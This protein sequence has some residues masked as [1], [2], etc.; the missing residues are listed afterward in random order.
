MIKLKVDEYITSFIVSSVYEFT[1]IHKLHQMCFYD[2]IKYNTLQLFNIY[3][4][5]TP[6]WGSKSIFSITNE[7]GRNTDWYAR[8]YVGT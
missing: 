6:T 7:N 2:D 3:S 1:F 8:K 5:L 4:H